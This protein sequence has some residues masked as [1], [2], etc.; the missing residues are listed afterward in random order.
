VSG[1]GRFD[2]ELQR[3]LDGGASDGVV[4]QPDAGYPTML[5]CKKTG[6][7][8]WIPLTGP[9]LG[10]PYGTLTW[11]PSGPTFRFRVDAWGLAPGDYTIVQYIDP[12]PGM[13][14][15]DIASATVGADGVLTVP[16]TSYELDRDLTTTNG[17]VWIV[18]SALVDTATDMF[19]AWDV[20]A[21][22][23]ELDFVVYDD[24]DVP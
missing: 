7:P 14:A 16:E 3:D 13:P 8:D 21:I 18:P 11:V 10:Y 6:A 12:Y 1:C 20:T 22:F 15:T 2:F 19:V 9:A 24:T 5:L 4:L 17:K 23:F